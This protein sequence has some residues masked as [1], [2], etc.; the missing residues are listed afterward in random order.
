MFSRR[1]EL[2][3]FAEM[4]EKEEQKKALERE[5]RKK[6][7]LAQKMHYL[8]STVQVGVPV[9]DSSCKPLRPRA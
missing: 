6:D 9:P 2:E 1:K 4:K 7:Y 5:K 3:E 8:L